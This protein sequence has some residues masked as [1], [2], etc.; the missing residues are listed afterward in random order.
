MKIIL[1]Y[2]WILMNIEDENILSTSVS[3]KI[4]TDAPT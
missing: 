4:D 2:D 1:K 3:G